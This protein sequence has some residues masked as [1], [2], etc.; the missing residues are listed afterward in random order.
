MKMRQL[1]ERIEG[2]FVKVKMGPYTYSISK[3][4]ETSFVKF[5]K[6]RKQIPDGPIS[7]DKYEELA[8]KFGVKIYPDKVLGTYADKY[9]DYGMDHYLVDPKN[10]SVGIELLLRQKRWF[11]IDGE[12]EKKKTDHGSSDGFR[13]SGQLWEPCDKCGSEPSY[14]PLGLCAKCW[15]K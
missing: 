1:L 14:M 10:R 5:M 15:P 9:G 8:K 6:D 13:K 2:E 11:A 4:D 3:D 12:D 7:R